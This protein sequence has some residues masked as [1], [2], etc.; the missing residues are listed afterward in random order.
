MERDSVLL[1]WSSQAIDLNGILLASPPPC[2]L[3]DWCRPRGVEAAPGAQSMRPMGAWGGTA[4][5]NEKENWKYYLMFWGLLPSEYNYVNVK[6]GDGSR[7]EVLGSVAYAERRRPSPEITSEKNKCLPEMHPGILPCFILTR[8]NKQF[9]CARHPRYH[10]WNFT[11]PY[12]KTVC[13]RL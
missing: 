10:P 1:K 6:M 7:G 9:E 2:L 3:S 12:W 5:G 4:W 13:A 11:D 8:K